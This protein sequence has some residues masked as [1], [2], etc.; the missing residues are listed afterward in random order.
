VKL[1]QCFGRLSFHIDQPLEASDC[2]VA[3]WHASGTGKRSGI[4]V[5]MGGYCLFCMRDAKVLRVEFF[6]SEGA[7]LE[8]A[9]LTTR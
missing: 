4:D 9:S 5:D 8:A 6:E 2:L 1:W 7:A 3:R